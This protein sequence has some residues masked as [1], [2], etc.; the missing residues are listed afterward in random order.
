MSKLS[1]FLILDAARMG[2]QIIRAKELNPEHRSLFH[3]L[4]NTEGLSGV[5][6]Y[7]FQYEPDSDFF[8]W[9]LEN[10]WG[11]SWGIIVMSD[12]RLRH[13]HSHFQEFLN[14]KT[15]D[16]KEFYFRFYDPRVI[17]TF[18]LSCDPGQLRDFFDDI[19]RFIV[20]KP[21]T[22]TITLYS[23]IKGTLQVNEDTISSLT[24]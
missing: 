12:T 13:L 6:P 11:K 22:D 3:G 15:E 10:G 18:L 4:K 17:G 8:T 9:F 21:G 2:E 7:L 1:S 20:E 23:L 19:T 5:A 24:H 14:V 16:G